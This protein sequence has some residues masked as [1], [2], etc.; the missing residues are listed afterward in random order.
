MFICLSANSIE[1]PTL[2]C[3]SGFMLI[4]QLRKVTSIMDKQK[5]IDALND[6]LAGELQ[7]VIQYLTYSAKVTGHWRP[8]LVEFMQKEIP[9]EL[10]HAQFLA[11]KI[12]ALGGTPTTEPR[13]VPE[14]KD[15]H[16]ML[17]AILKAEKKAVKNYTERAKQ[18]DE[19]GDKGLVV[20]LEDIVRDETIHAEET[21]KLL[22]NWE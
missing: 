2:A 11:D 3:Y 21:E 17:E 22:R 18:A 13:S 20:Q 6:D 15:A 7:A 10:G 19:Y 1:V 8:Q 4:T 14:A 16:S 9:D 5:L 12:A